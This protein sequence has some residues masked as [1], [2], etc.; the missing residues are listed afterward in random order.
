MSNYKRQ[1]KKEE[2]ESG[3]TKNEF[4][5]EL[6]LGESGEEFYQNG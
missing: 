1:D 6:L 4:V 3:V 5:L 2:K